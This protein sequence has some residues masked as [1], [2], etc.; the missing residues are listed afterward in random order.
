[1]MTYYEHH[2][3]FVADNLLVVLGGF[4]GYM[5]SVEVFEI[6]ANGNVAETP[7]ECKVVDMPDG[8]YG[9]QAVTLDGNVVTC[10]GSDR[11]RKL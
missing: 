5:S 9:L 8:L 1:M 11:Y 10:G 6:D 7:V 4:P 2:F 3:V